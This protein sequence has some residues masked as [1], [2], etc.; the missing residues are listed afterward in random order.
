MA[1][2]RFTILIEEAIIVFRFLN[3]AEE[4]IMLALIKRAAA[5][6]ALRVIFARSVGIVML[7]DSAFLY[8]TTEFVVA[9]ATLAVIVGV[10]ALASGLLLHAQI[11]V[12]LAVSVE[13]TFVLT[14]EIRLA[15]ALRYHALVLDEITGLLH[16]ATSHLNR[17]VVALLD[18]RHQ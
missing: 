18:L 4:I 12:H 10:A 7:F 11:R 15:R 9:A 17:H 8:S 13:A 14:L 3:N 6:V 5:T 2:G 1:A 16:R